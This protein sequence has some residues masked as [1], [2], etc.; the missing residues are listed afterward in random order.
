MAA[1]ALADIA[2]GQ[3]AETAAIHLQTANGQGQR[4]ALAVRPA[5]AQFRLSRDG[6]R[7][8]IH[9]G[10]GRHGVRRLHQVH[11]RLP[12]HLILARTQHGQQPRAH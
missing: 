1:A 4:H 9:E 6:A 3:Q 2:G 12:H 5:E 11:E 7:T 8:G 10:G